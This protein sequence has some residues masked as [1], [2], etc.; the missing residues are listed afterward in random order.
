[1]VSYL[2]GVSESFD[3]K[4]SCFLVKRNLGRKKSL[5]A[6]SRT[7]LKFAFLFISDSKRRGIILLAVK[8]MFLFPLFF[9][10]KERD[11]FHK[12]YFN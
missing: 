9:I 4:F 5:V 2:E 6:N 12:P 3:F 7:N 8:T 1:M 11:L 10:S